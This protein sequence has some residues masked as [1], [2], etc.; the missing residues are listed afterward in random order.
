MTS[1]RATSAATAS[2]GLRIRRLSTDTKD[3]LAGLR[4]RY[5][6]L[7]EGGRH[8]EYGEVILYIKQQTPPEVWRLMNAAEKR[9]WR[10][11]FP[12]RGGPARH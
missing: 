3:R 9:A 11:V 8:H 7:T 12:P 10:R 2:L 4:A 6:V 5:Y 1:S